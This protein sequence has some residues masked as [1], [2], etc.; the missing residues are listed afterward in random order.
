MVAEGRIIEVSVPMPFTLL[1]C[2]LRTDYF[3]SGRRLVVL[4]FDTTIVFPGIVQ[5]AIFYR[6]PAN[7]AHVFGYVVL[8]AVGQFRFLFV[9]ADDRHAAADRALHAHFVFGETVG[10]GVER[11]QKRVDRRGFC[12][13]TKDKKMYVTNVSRKAF[14]RANAFAKRLYAITDSIIINAYF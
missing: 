14:G 3:Q 2:R 10:G 11:S 12:T 7:A 6:Q 13:C 1:G 4:L 8:V 9:P 5:L